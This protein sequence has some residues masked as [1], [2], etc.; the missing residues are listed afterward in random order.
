MEGH[1]MV[2]SGLFGQQSSRS[3]AAER[4]DDAAGGR[5]DGAG[6]RVVTTMELPD[7]SEDASAVR[8]EAVRVIEQGGVILLPALPFELKPDESRLFR[9]EMADPRSKNISFDPLKNEL[10]GAVGS[11]AEQTALRGMIE[12]YANESRDLIARLF[13]AYRGALFQGRTSFRPVSTATRETSWRK[14]DRLIHVDSFPSRPTRGSRILRVFSNVDPSGRPR[15]WRIGPSFGDIA[16]ALLPRIPRP[17]SGLAPLLAALRITK[18]RRS[19]YDHIML[20]IHDLMKSNPGFQQEF[21]EV[22]FPAGSTWICF[23]DQVAHAVV[24][25]QH[26]LEHTTLL[27]VT[28]MNRPELSPL[29]ILESLAGR[30][31]A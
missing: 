22:D 4:G 16:T 14:D 28:S 29:R 10:R 27:P 1:Q 31:L 6:R 12:R 24:S 8:A 2:E 17:V 13:P 7:R 9:E 23:S 15:T 3:V 21:T 18:G 30:T 19:H 5:V 25:G 20:K 26:V 11:S